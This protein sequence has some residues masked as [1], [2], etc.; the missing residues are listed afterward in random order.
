MLLAARGHPEGT[1]P[2]HKLTC[3]TADTEFIG[4]DITWQNVLCTR[5]KIAVSIEFRWFQDT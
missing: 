4:T 1:G 5:D 3:T 2:C